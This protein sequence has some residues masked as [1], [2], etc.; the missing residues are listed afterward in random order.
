VFQPISDSWM[1]ADQLRRESLRERSVLDLCTGSGLLAVTAALHGAAEVMA[2][3]VSRRSL[4]SVRLNAALNGVRVKPRRGDLFEAVGERRFDVI[5]T[6]P[7]YVPSPAADL[8][9]RGPARAWEGG[10]DG[11]VFIDRICAAAPAHL[12]RGGVLFLVQSAICGEGQ[13]LTALRAGG[14]QARVVFRHDGDLGPLMRAR[15]DW[16][17]DRGL[18]VDRRDEVIV[19]R[20][21]AA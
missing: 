5:T 19:V 18:A 15:W 7:P 8:P 9:N 13:T 20:A 1:L 6:N 3:D 14:L 21:Q 4:L 2:V 12:N 10:P 11:R 17:R 16:L